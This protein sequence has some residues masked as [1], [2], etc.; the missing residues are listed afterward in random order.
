MTE[1]LDLLK[2][3]ERARARRK[4]LGGV[5]GARRREAIAASLDDTRS[6]VDPNGYRLSDRLWNARQADRDAIDN[7]LRES[8]ARA[9]DP[10]QTA[11]KLEAYLTPVGAQ[12]TTSTPRSGRGLYAARR[13]ARTETTRAFGQA[14][15]EAAKRARFPQIIRWRVSG[16]HDP[17]IDK[18]VCIDNQSNGPYEPRD[19]PRYPAHPNCRCVLLPEPKDDPLDIA[20]QLRQELQG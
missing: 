19:V 12:Q 3:A 8:I 20:R 15:I 11:K 7:L 14:T 6:W 10:I 9:D 16:R 2:A 5:E 1:P 17:R 4:I 18:G 13:L